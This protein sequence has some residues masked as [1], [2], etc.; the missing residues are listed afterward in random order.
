V[1][2]NETVK[3]ELILEDAQLFKLFRQYQDQFKI[4]LD[5]G[6]FDFIIGSKTIHKNG[7]T[8]K[9]IETNLIRRY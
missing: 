3:I 4:L 1:D 5:N 2:K 9:V 7:L 6:V 8:I